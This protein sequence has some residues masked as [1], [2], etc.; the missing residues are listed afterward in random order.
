MNLLMLVLEDDKCFL[1]YAKASVSCKF[2]TC[3]CKVS[4]FKSVHW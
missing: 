3:R 4:P 1:K 2:V